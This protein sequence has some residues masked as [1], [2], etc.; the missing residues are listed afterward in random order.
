MSAVATS[1]GE[2]VTALGFTLQELQWA[3]WLTTVDAAT[4]TPQQ[5]A[6]LDESTPSAR[7]SPYYLT[8]LHDV[9]AL[10]ERSRLFN[11]V[12]YGQ[13]GLPR[14]ERELSTVAVSRVNGCPYCASVHARLFVQLAKDR[15]SAWRLLDEGVATP[16]S[17][18]LRALVD[19][20]V[21]LSATPPSAGAREIAALRAAGLDALE[22]L[23][24]THAIAMF[25]WANRLMQT[26]GE[27][28]YPD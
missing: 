11:A 3:S 9:D 13:G 19:Y 2:P 23:D 24:A 21:A 26:L 27:P 28:V 1:A 16:L 12:M 22:I 25:A 8:L 18:R 14:A 6:V 7:T 10:R 4:A 15:D 5:L 17:P 20:A